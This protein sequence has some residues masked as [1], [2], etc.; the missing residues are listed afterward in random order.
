MLTKHCP[1]KAKV[2]IKLKIMILQFLKTKITPKFIVGVDV[3]KGVRVGLGVGV[4]E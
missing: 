4:K 3:G 1:N 2:Y